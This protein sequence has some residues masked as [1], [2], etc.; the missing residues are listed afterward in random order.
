MN[1]SYPKVAARA[2]ERCEYCRAPEQVFNFS[3]QVEHIVPRSM[4][5]AQNLENLALACESC[6][7]Y[8]SDAM[9]GQ[10]GDESRDVRLFNPRRDRWDDHFRLENEAGILHGLTRV[11]RAT[12]TRLRMNSDFQVR[13]RQHWVT[14]GLYP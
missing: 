10:D 11:G 4:G 3:F 6:N 2:E 13:A 14:L 9:F 5:G 8:K 7:L 12:V 1:R